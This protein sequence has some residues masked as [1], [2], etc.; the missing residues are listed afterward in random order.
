MLLSLLS[1]LVAVQLVVSDTSPQPAPANCKKL[2]TD[3]DWPKLDVWKSALPGVEARRGKVDKSRTT[4]DY[5]FKANSV[6]QVQKAIKFAA[7]HNVRLSVVN[8]GHGRSSIF[9]SVVCLRLMTSQISWDGSS[10]IQ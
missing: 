7:E 5:K 4:P 8:S 3:A 9:S 1:L 2:P 10:M 6:E